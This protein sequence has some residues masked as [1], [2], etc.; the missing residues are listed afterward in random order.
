MQPELTHAR[1]QHEFRAS[2]NTDGA[3]DGLIAP[4]PSEVAER[5]KVYRNNVL[6]SLTCALAA[7]F[8][9]VKQLVGA[10]FFAP[11]ARAYIAASPP[12]SPVLLRWG[13][14]FAPFLDGFPPVAHLRFLG[15]VARLEFARGMACHA[16]DADPISPDALSVANLEQLRLKLHPAVTLFKASTP[17]VQIW[18][19]H[20]PGAEAASLTPGPDYAVIARRPDFT[21]LVEQVAPGTFAVLSSLRGGATLG[22]AAAEAD[23]TPA[24]T[25]LLQ[26]G[27]ISDAQKGPPA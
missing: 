4:D 20:Q 25:L 9:V 2:L 15:D 16:A 27:L 17:A 5:F 24:L 22:D 3:P 14:S 21:I 11:L 1:M 6:H 23:P 13:D 18:H 26:H 10:D 19:R 7:R 8:P 12:Q